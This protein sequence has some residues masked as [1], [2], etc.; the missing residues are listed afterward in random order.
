MLRLQWP[1]SRQEAPPP[2]TRRLRH[3]L[4]GPNSYHC[5][6]LLVPSFHPSPM[7]IS[8]SCL[9]FSIPG[10]LMRK[11]DLQTFESPSFPNAFICSDWT[12]D[13][14]SEVTTFGINSHKFRIAYNPKGQNTTP[15]M[16]AGNKALI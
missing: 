10:S 2:L 16:T 9:D 15:A 4:P 7:I 14:H 3:P 12:P 1:G 8:I 6:L 5:S 13:K 11:S